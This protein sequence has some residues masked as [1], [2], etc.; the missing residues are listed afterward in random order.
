M[1]TINTTVFP[2]DAYVLVEVDWTDYPDVLY[3]G[4]SRR[5]T[6]TGEVVNLRPYTAFDGDGNLLLS[7]GLG[8]WWDTEPPL[9]VPLE[10][11]TFAADV[12]TV[13]TTN[14]D[15]EVALAPWTGSGGAL[16]RSNAFSHGGTWSAELTPT[17]VSGTPS[18]ANLTDSAPFIVGVPLVL[19]GWMMSPQ[20]WGAV[21][22][23][24]GIGYD[25]GETESFSTPAEII[26][27]GQWTFLRTTLTPT[28][29][30][31]IG[32]LFA[33]ALAT[34][35]A[36]V[37]FYVDDVGVY[38]AQPLGVTACETVTVTSEAIWLKSPLN[39]CDDVLLGMCDPAMD[40]DCEEDSRVTYA[41]MAEDTLD[42]NTVL[43]EPANRQYPI[44]TSRI[45]RKPRSEL[46]LLAHDCDARDAVLQINEPGTPL[47]FQ[48]PQ[49]YCIP[50]RYISVGPVTEA[51]FSVDQRDDFRLMLMPYAVVQR[52]E[53]PANGICGARIEDLCDIY[54]SWQS[55]VL[56]G[57]TYYD[58]LL[59]LASD[60][61]PFSG[62]F[63]ALRTWDEVLVEFADW[64]AVEGG[65]TRDWD[66][67]RFGL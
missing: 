1:P 63:A 38:Q 39:P 61:G 5:N 62:D 37:L 27:D 22:L 56:A 4:V 36:S 43:S 8:L 35:P 10:Y 19:Q 33:S 18:A 30:G 65:G 23:T 6:A 32:N 51:R 13:I 12:L 26:D 25:D 48:A 57:L 11:C 21:R 52:P 59:G 16:V 2:A 67:L 3:A 46:R 29:P 24:A 28:K 20:G 34:P 45:R 7:C 9:N 66:E 15:F 55:M 41:G 64:T 50:D 49:D 31:F 17:G 54:T 42:A 47:L 40:F 58:L 44:P 53:G 60:E 14:P